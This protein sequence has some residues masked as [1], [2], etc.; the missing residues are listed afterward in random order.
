M[1]IQYKNGWVELIGVKRYIRKRINQC[2]DEKKAILLG[3]LDYKIFTLDG[4]AKAFKEI[5]DKLELIDD[6]DKIRKNIM[7]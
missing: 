3:N 2:E 7:Q 5:L 4:Q 1:D 6:K